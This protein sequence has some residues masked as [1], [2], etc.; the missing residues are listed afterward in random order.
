MRAAL[1]ASGLA[2]PA[3]RITV[4]LAPADL[5]KEGSHYDLPIALGADG[6]D[7]ARSRRDALADY[8]V[9]GELGSTARSR[10][11]PACCRRPSPPMPRD[12]GLICPVACGP[13]AAW[14][15]PELPILA[16]ASL[17]RSSII[18]RARRC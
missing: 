10:R 5:P 8:T 1:I 14:A 18:S 9:L 7:R 12:E 17:I 15:S 2:L 4:N 11:W 6:G 3:Q 16:A 13:E